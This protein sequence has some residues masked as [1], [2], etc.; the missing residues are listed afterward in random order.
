MFQLHPAIRRTFWRKGE[1]TWSRDVRHRKQRGD[2]I[3]GLVLVLLAYKPIWY[4]STRVVAV[5][6][7]L[8]P[9]HPP[10]GRWLALLGLG[11][12]AHRFEIVADI[13]RITREQLSSD[14]SRF[15]RI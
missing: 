5:M 4:T 9:I 14:L 7:P 6:N 1:F 15:G 3:R 12:L 11:H 13:A 8:C 10:A 2:K